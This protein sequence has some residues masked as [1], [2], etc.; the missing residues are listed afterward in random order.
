[1]M[2]DKVLITGGSGGIGNALCNSFANAGY[3]V[4]LHYN[5]N[6]ERA[7]SVLKKLPGTDH[8][9]IKADLSDVDQISAMF[10]SIE[11]IDVVINNAA[12][13]EPHNLN[14]LKYEEWVDVWRR[15]IDTN[16]IGSAH[17]MFFSSR[18]MKKSGGGKFINISSRGAFR[19]EP[20]APAYGASKAGLNSLGQS[21]AVALAKDNIFVYTLAPG[22]VNTDRV[23]DL[24]DNKVKSQSPL[25]RVAKPEEVA[26]T[27]LW[28]AKE[29]NEFLTGSIIDINGAS[30]LRS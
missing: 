5:S 6:Q 30:Y 23:K 10:K 15:T 19:G 7:E 3:T 27:A 21:M 2:N 12:V 26:K 1:M 25:N 20:S 18:A 28:L 4:I 13:V 9:T 17:I 16:L 11:N 29:D 24:I 22:F 14:K 8:I